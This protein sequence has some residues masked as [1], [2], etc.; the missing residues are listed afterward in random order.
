MLRL[1]HFLVHIIYA[2]LYT[3]YIR[4]IPYILCYRQA[5]VEEGVYAVQY[6]ILINSIII[7]HRPTVYD[8]QARWRLLYSSSVHLFFFQCFSL[9][10]TFLRINTNPHGTIQTH[11]S[12][13]T[14]C[15]WA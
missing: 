12:T 5:R 6:A 4:Y 7:M 14:G 11:I 3:I 8:L 13:F 10:Y 15:I 2:T 9:N 1:S